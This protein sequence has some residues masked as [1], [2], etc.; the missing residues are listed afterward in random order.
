MRPEM[1][2]CHAETNK[3]P[4]EINPTPPETNKVSFCQWVKSV[5]WVNLL[6]IKGLYFLVKSVRFV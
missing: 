4:P 6:K 3:M 5:F 2:N 1:N